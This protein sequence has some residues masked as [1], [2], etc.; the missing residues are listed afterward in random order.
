MCTATYLPFGPNGFILTHSR[1]EKAIRPAARPPETVRLGGMKVT[2]PQDPQGKG[3]WIAS[4]SRI[5]SS[6]QTAVGLLNG[7]FI[8]HLS[9]PPYRHSRG[10][11][12]LHFFTYASINAFVTTYDFSGIEPFTLL[13]IEAGGPRG[14]RVVE[15][16]WNG[17]RLFVR[18]KDPEQPNIWSSVTL[19]SADVIRKR[20][21]WFW[22]WCYRHPNPSVDDIRQFHRS[23][24]SGDSE[25]GL[26]M[27]RQDT[28]L[29]VSLTTIVH[30]EDAVAE[31]ADRRAT[32]PMIYEDFMQHTGQQQPIN[33]SY[34]TA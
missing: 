17:N 3:T 12:P 11:V 14:R 8:P 27:N 7:S 15:L 6:V 9:Q 32:E 16:R 30:Q 19:Y 2:F 25:N 22:D 5:G 29:T 4:G 20:E 21:R 10:L 24:G 13:I 31:T 33:Q 1:D 23:A 34:A 28:L 26:R 18:E